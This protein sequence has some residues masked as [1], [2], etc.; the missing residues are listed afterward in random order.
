MHAPV[1]GKAEVGRKLKLGNTTRRLTW[2]VLGV[3]VFF[4]IGASLSYS[5]RKGRLAIVPLFDDSSYLVD[6]LQRLK[7]FDMAGIAGLLET[8]YRNPPHSPFTALLSTFGFVLTPGDMFG[9]YALSGLWVIVILALFAYVL[10][11]L[12]SLTLAGILCALVALPIF[13]TVIQVF[14]PDISW[15]LLTGCTATIL[16]ITDLPRASYRKFL[17]LGLL[18]G[19]ALLSKPTGMPAGATVIGIGY[20]AS[21]AIALTEQ[22]SSALRPLT[23]GTALIAISAAVVAFP[24]YAIAGEHVLAYIRMVMVDQRE[25]WQMPGSL[26]EHLLYFLQP[27]LATSM[28]GWLWWAGIGAT[29]AHGVYCIVNWKSASGER[30]RFMATLI[31]VCFAYAIPSLS[32]VKHSYIG[33]LFYGTAAMV[34]IWNIGCLLRLVPVKPAVVALAGLLIFVVFWRPANINTELN[35]AMWESDKATKTIWP[36]LSELLPRETEGARAPELYIAS[37]GPIFDKTLEY[38]VLKQGLAARVT[39]GFTTPTLADALKQASTADIVVVSETGALG[40]S[41]APFPVTKIQDQLMHALEH[42][43]GFRILSS[44]SDFEGR[45]TLVFAKRGP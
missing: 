6:G 23:I 45:R 10:R 3:L 27:R 20:F 39:S 38:F 29:I 4:H 42:D 12:P 32:P 9:A 36:P 35:A 5:L 31:V 25:L 28:L 21:V 22:G 16:A 43:P 1:G 26:R 41:G 17:L 44:Y 40:Q 13:S 18:V 7:A 30:K 34:F 19:F 8:F 2:F 33:C 37:I 11:D 15:G 14:R 24:Y